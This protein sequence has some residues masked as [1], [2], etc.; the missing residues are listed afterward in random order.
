VLHQRT[1]RL[2]KEE[3]F[4]LVER[5]AS[6]LPRPWSA[7]RG[8]PRALTLLQAVEATVIYLRR[9]H[10]QETIGEFYDVSQSTISR[11]IGVLTPLVRAA[12]AHCVPDDAQV[13]ATIA[14][15][16]VLVDGTLA[17]VWS[18]RGHREL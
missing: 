16:I 12:T 8:R 14:D 18:W 5:V 10:V 15:R 7:P 11:I 6:L 17:P 9:N 13:A 4:A 3:L 1:S 2:S